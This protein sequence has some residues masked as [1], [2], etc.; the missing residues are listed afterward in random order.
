VHLLPKF[1]FKNVLLILVLLVQKLGSNPLT[2]TAN[3]SDLSVFDVAKEM[4][5][6][7]R[8]LVEPREQEKYLP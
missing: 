5:K 2:L 4:R 1:G 3:D 6:L 8:V 7:P